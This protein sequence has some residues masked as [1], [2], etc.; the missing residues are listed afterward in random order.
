MQDTQKRGVGGSCGWIKILCGCVRKIILARHLLQQADASSRVPFRILFLQGTGGGSSENH[1]GV[2]PLGR[3]F[4]LSNNPATHVQNGFVH[5]F[6]MSRLKFESTARASFP[7]TPS[8]EITN[9]G[10][11][12]CSLWKFLPCISIF[13]FS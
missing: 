4:D 7:N 6:A 9:G 2:R 1:V 3:D 11:C 10:K 5:F 13:C 12:F 8:T